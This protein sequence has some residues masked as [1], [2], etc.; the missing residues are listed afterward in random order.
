MAATEIS[1][2]GLRAIAVILVES[3]FMQLIWIHA[4]LCSR[5]RNGHGH[6]HGHQ[7]HYAYLVGGAV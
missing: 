2:D 1:E 5:F 4:S 7:A 3:M 6:E